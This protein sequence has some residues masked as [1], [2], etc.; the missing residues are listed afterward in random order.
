MM[1]CVNAGAS[2][3]RPERHQAII[4]D[5]RQ[6]SASAE[7]GPTDIA[8]RRRQHQPAARPAAVLGARTTKHLA[9]HA[10]PRLLA[11]AT[12]QRLVQRLRR[13]EL[14]HKRTDRRQLSRR[15]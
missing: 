9:P 13:T 12:L 7:Q 5:S 2:L 6:P 8:H 14:Q 11:A 3:A 15:L 10:E 1:R 4:I